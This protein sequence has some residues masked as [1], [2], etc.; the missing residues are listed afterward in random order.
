MLTSPNGIRGNTTKLKGGMF[1]GNILRKFA[2]VLSLSSY[3]LGN[4][5]KSTGIFRFY[6]TF[7]KNNDFL[8]CRGCNL[9]EFVR[10]LKWYEIFAVLLIS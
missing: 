6:E 2:R 10:I 8:T 3:I 5:S 7:C 9:N 4:A 1:Y